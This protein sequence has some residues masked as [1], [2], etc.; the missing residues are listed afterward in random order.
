MDREYCV[1]WEYTHHKYFTDIYHRKNHVS[2]QIFII[3]QDNLNSQVQ[4]MCQ[5]NFIVAINGLYWNYPQ[6]C[7]SYEYSP[8]AEVG[9]Q[10]EH[11]FVV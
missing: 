3:L 10:A 7:M 6:D 8:E 5:N 4:G 2:R 11:L 9:Y 1:K